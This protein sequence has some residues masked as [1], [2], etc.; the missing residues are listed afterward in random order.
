MSSFAKCQNEEEDEDE[1]DGKEDDDD[2][3]KD[4]RRLLGVSVPLFSDQR[5]VW[6]FVP[7]SMAQMG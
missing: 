5:V 2:D 3:D 4:R 1:G 6:R 7:R